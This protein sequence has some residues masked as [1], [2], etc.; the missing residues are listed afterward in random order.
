MQYLLHNR[1]Y[2]LEWQRTELVL[3]QEIVQILLEHLKHQARVILVLKYLVGAHQIV[4]V[5]VFLSESR[6]NAH[7]DLALARIRRMILEN[8]YSHNLVGALIPALH[9]LTECATT[10]ELE[11]LV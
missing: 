7:L 2:T 6:Q 9:H 5:G 4:L 10:E 8:L 1:S 11:H 3:L